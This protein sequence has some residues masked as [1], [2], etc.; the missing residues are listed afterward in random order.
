MQIYEIPYAASADWRQIREAVIGEQPWSVVPGI[1]AFAQL[2]WN[3]HALMVRL[4]AEEPEIL[5]RFTS[6]YDMV[7]LD[8][9]LEFFFAP[10]CADTRYLN[11][12]S[13]P[14]GAMF[15]GIGHGRADL[16]RLHPWDL[17][18]LF[19]VTPFSCPGGWGVTYQIPVS[20][21][22][23]FFP[24]FSLFAGKMLRGNFYKCGDETPQPHHLAWNSIS[25]PAPDFHCPQFFG[26]L[27][28]VR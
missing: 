6:D 15:L 8:S 3:E 22:R 27:R 25:L 17:Q 24:D 4:R 1:R 20:F 2:A 11:I 23:L 14:A 7:C 12:E 10:D 21:L 16:T 13:N 26:Q 19:R 5:C 9:C 28:C 18:T